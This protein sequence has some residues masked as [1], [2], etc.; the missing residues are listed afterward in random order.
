MTKREKKST[1]YAAPLSGVMIGAIVKE[2][3]LQDRAL[4]DK[5]ARRYFNG[6]RVSDRKR[7]EIVLALGNALTE[8]HIFPPSTS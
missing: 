1:T 7:A 8:L 4:N 6:T 5:T 2:L 3:R